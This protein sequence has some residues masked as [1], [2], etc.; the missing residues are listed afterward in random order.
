MNAGAGEK[1]SPRE[2]FEILA[3]RV[4]ALFAGAGDHTPTERRDAIADCLELM[5]QAAGDME[6]EVEGR[7]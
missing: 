2:R 1:L 5:A 6:R 3:N 7:A 4:D